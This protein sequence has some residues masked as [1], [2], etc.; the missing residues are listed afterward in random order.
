VAL[1]RTPKVMGGQEE[2]NNG[3]DW[4]LEEEL[5]RCAMLGGS[6][7]KNTCGS[8]RYTP[9]LFSVRYQRRGILEEGRKLWKE[10]TGWYKWGGSSIH[11]MAPLR[12]RRLSN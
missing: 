7:K 5:R 9:I 1:C 2:T 4:C 6:C 11:R 8:A 3:A 10:K 12:R